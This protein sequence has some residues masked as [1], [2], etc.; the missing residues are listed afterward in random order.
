VSPPLELTVV[1]SYGLVGGAERWLLDLIDATDRCR[2]DVVLLGPGALA[3]EFASRGIPHRTITAGRRAVDLLRPTAALARWLRERRPDVVVANGFKAALVA[4]AAGRAVGVRTVWATHDHSFDGPASRA[5][6][7]LTDAAVAS[8]P[9]L[10]TASRHRW[11]EVVPPARPTTPHADRATARRALQAHG[12]PLDGLLMGMVGRLVPYKGCEDAVRALTHP[13][14][15]PWRLALVGP[16][17]PGGERERLERLAASL[18]VADRLHLTGTIDDARRLMT[19]FDTL[20]VLTRAA[21]HGPDRE[22][23]GLSAL[24]AMVAGVPVVTAGASPVSRR[25]AGCAG[26]VVDPADPP[27]LAAALASLADPG[28]RE[29]LGR[30]GRR[31]AAEHPEAPECADRLVRH[32][33]EVARRPGAGLRPVQPLSVVT[34]VKDEADAADE[35]VTSLRPQLREDDEL[36]I[37]DGGSADA[38]TPR[39]REHARRDPRLTVLLAPGS[40]ISAGRNAAIAAARHPRVVGTDAGCRPSP[41]WLDAFR[42]AAAEQAAPALLTGVYRVAAS[43]PLQAAVAAVGYPDVGEL[44]HP[45]PLARAYGRLLGRAFDAGRPTGRSFSVTTAAWAEAGGFPEG[46]A[47]GEDVL[48]GQAVAARRGATLVADAE[49]TWYQRST[50][51]ATARMYYAY[52]QGSGRSRAP[53]LLG[54]DLARAAAYPAAVLLFQ[55]RGAARML[56]VLGALVYLSLPWRRAAGAPCPALVVLAV[57]PAAALRDLAK[58]AGALA[59][60]AQHRR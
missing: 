35:L 24:E 57:P 17:E 50:L 27:A 13:D 25:L 36:I 3:D 2:I 38:T 55:R 5:A 59:G 18:G 34:T 10:A 1:S 9:E 6:S 58:A 30:A 21:G 42:S 28:R 32:L 16:D 43:G 31:L 23:F 52:G 29:R 48:F 39:L 47:T 49:V 7:R 14:A 53:A 15:A 8:S 44:R 56:G 45:T 12:V 11:V 37:V 41:G 19:G 51:A 54:R 26:L 40:G 4:G 60:L 33:A 20:A 46:L 22:G